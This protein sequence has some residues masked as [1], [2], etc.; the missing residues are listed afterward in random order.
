M[1][2]VR[3][4]RLAIPGMRAGSGA[5]SCISPLLVAKQ[6]VALLTISSTLRS[7]L[8]GLTKTMATEFAADNVLINAVLPGHILTDRQI[9][10][11]KLRAEQ[12]A[13]RWTRR[14]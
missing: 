8:S 14:C 5:A 12:E 11:G 1:N 3:L 2:V 9:H 13:S 6:P 10:L 4:C 7:G